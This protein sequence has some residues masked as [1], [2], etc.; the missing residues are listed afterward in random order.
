MLAEIQGPAGKAAEIVMGTHGKVSSWDGGE[1]SNCGQV[2]AG[3][4]VPI[5]HGHCFRL[6]MW[7]PVAVAA[8]KRAKKKQMQCL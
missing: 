4:Q 3:K 8:T 2:A 7:L 5:I 1:V 6:P